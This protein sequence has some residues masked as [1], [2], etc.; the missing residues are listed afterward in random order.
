MS[1]STKWRLLGHLQLFSRA[2]A[3]MA[4]MEL[5]PQEQMANARGMKVFAVEIHGLPEDFAYFPALCGVQSS[6][7]V[8]VP[9][10][11]IFWVR[12][13]GRHRESL[14]ASGLC[15]PELSAQVRRA[16]S[17]TSCKPGSHGRFHYTHRPKR[18]SMHRGR[19]SRAAAEGVCGL[20]MNQSLSQLTKCIPLTAHKFPEVTKLQAASH[21]GG[22]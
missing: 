15:S 22:R 7:L 11:P 19:W 12:Y 3:V 2:V 14:C 21:V 9:D 17:C 6:P 16:K 20:N 5:I 18:L 13:R 8:F 10:R 1:A 4:E